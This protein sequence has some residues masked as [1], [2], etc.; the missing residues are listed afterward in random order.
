MTIESENKIQILERNGREIRVGEIKYVIIRNHH[1]WRTSKVVLEV[2][3]DKLVL[4]K[5]DLIR[6]VNNA[7]N[8]D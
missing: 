2:G 7:T 5:N 4:D 1:N 6:A 3:E 8:T